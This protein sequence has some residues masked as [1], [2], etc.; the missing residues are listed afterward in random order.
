MPRP[1]QGKYFIQSMRIL[2]LDPGIARCGWAIILKNK[3]KL[4]AEK[5]G[6]F[7][8]SAK[9]SLEKRL[10]SLFEAVCKVIGE[11]KPE[12]LVVEELFFNTNAKTVFVVGQARGV[13]IL[14]AG[15]SK[16]P[17]VSYTPLQVKVAIT[18][19]GHAPKQQVGDMVKRSLKLESLPPLDDTVDALAIALTHAFSY[20]HFS[21]Y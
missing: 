21:K 14:A 2:G 4:S 18:G 6:C 5:Y 1:D 3:G 16:I 17:V 20:K 11:Y 8:T 10:F 15:I 19:Y 7:E 13:V 12:V 9:L